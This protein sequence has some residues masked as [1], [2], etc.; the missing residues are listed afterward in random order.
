M[1]TKQVRLYFEAVGDTDINLTV[2]G[3]Q[4]FSGTIGNDTPWIEFDYD[5][6]EINLTRPLALSNRYLWGGSW[7]YDFP[8]RI[9]SS[10]STKL[11]KITANYTPIWR[12]QACLT[13]VH[14]GTKD[15]FRIIHDKTYH[16][17][18]ELNLDLPISLYGEE[19]LEPNDISFI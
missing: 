7:T 1:Q 5:I 6:E 12:Y 19:F 16:I 18:M 4:K 8:A 14:P 15:I 3:S 11:V 17:P 10:Q 2:N 9:T 13:K